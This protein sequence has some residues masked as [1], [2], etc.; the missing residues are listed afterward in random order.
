MKCL[1]CALLLILGLLPV[2]ISAYPGVVIVNGRC[3][4]CDKP[5]G[6]AVYVNGQEYRSFGGGNVILDRPG[7]NGP[8]QVYRRGG[9]TIVNGNC[10]VCNVDV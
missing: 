9:T 6:E 10:K 8:T 2:L 5:D 4:N 7:Y 1:T 3:L